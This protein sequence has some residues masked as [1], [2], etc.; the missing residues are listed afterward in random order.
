LVTRPIRSKLEGAKITTLFFYSKKFMKK[1][2]DLTDK[3]FE[4]LSI[5]AVRSK[6]NLKNYIE[7]VLN[8]HVENGVILFGARRGFKA[9]KHSTER[10][11]NR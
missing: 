5:M 1:L 2:I 9:K 10:T 3:N 8:N 11:K 7:N 4:V 6:A